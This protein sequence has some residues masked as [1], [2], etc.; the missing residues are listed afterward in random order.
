[1]RTGQVQQRESRRGQEE[2]QHGAKKEHVDLT[3]SAYSPQVTFLCAELTAAFKS[4]NAVLPPWRQ[5]HSMLSKWQP[6][7]SLEID[8]RTAAAPRISFEDSASGI[9]QVAWAPPADSR[10]PESMPMRIMPSKME[11]H[12]VFGGFGAHGYIDQLAS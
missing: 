2:Q 10:A 1:M 7:K 11:P 12:K 4:Q 9:P 6:R 8:L 3:G 5:A